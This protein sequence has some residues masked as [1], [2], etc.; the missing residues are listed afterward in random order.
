MKRP[1]HLRPYVGSL[2]PKDAAIGMQIAR[3]N[4]LSLLEAAEELF[5]FKK[6]A[7]TTVLSILAIEEAA[8][9][10]IIFSILLSDDSREIEKMWKKYRTHT[11]KGSI[12]PYA[13]SWVIYTHH[14]KGRNK[15]LQEMVTNR[16]PRPETMEFIKQL[17]LYSDCFTDKVWTLPKDQ[18]N[19][20]KA[21]FMLGD[22]RAM[23]LQLRDYLP[24][25]LTI[26][27]QHLYGVNRMLPQERKSAFNALHR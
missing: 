12:Y 4:A 3:L 23:I 9:V 17:M 15:K 27:K 10:A 1:K 6:Y 21:K 22:A 20:K 11:A 5:N 8:K 25:E 24:E 2:N 18:A 7:L 16:T 14:P 19:R 13:I 26:W